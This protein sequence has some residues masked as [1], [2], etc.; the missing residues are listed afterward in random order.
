[1]SAAHAKLSASGSER[2]MNCPGSIKLSTNVPEPSESKYAV[3]G[4]KAHELFELWLN[5]AITTEKTFVIPEGYPKG[6]VEAVKTGV[7]ADLKIW[8]E[9]DRPELHAERKVSLGFIDKDRWGTLDTR[10]V[11]HFGKLFVLDYKHG[12]GIPVDVVDQ[13]K[14]ST[15]FN[16]NTQ[17]IYYALASAHE[18]DY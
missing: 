4:T 11:D 5:H 8:N 12:S 9:N 3:E 2:W 13:E 15:P 7:K 17:L 6:M 18:Y 16:H 10:I 14:T 1:M